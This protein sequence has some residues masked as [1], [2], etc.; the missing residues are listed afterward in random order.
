MNN[1][2]NEISNSI[3]QKFYL[4]VNEFIAK[5][6][7]PEVI[8]S[9]VSQAIDHVREAKPSLCEDE[10]T[11]LKEIVNEKFENTL[12]DLVLIQFKFNKVLD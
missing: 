11:S 2:L 7:K 12:E 8:P 10:L 3:F 4:R 1:I 5:L 9:V 6:I